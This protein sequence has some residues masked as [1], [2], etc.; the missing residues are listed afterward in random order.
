MKIKPSYFLL[1]FLFLI[2]LW[3]TPRLIVGPKEILTEPQAAQKLVYLV[4]ATGR[5]ER[6]LG[7]QRL[8]EKVEKGQDTHCGNENRYEN[9]LHRMMDANGNP[10]NAKL[11]YFKMVYQAFA[12]GEKAG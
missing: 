9:S 4:P 3:G 10:V 2:I 12:L 7:V 11:P 8:L 1:F 5:E 6:F